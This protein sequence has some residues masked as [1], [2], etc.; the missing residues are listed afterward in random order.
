[1]AQKAEDTFQARSHEQYSYLHTG[2]HTYEKVLFALIEEKWT[3]ANID[4]L[5]YPVQL[6]L[7]E[8]LRYTRSNFDSVKTCDWSAQVY[9]LIGRE[10]IISNLTA[11]SGIK[12]ATVPPTL[13]KHKTDFYISQQE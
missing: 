2:L 13:R 5:P 9:K 12:S 8:I 7:H 1:M 10:D 11:G 6:P 3:H 4:E